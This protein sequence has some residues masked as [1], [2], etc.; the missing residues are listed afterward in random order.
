MKIKKDDLVKIIAGA[1]KGK[2]GKVVKVLPVQNRVLVEGI[3]VVKRNIKPSQQHPQGGTKEV[4]KSIDVSNVAL[5]VGD[6]AARVGFNVTK[7]GNKTRVARNQS[8]KEIK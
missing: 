4:H 5:S 3:G 6:K 7:D 1:N 2:S 8:N